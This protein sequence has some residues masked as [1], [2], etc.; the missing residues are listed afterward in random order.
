MTNPFTPADG[1]TPGTSIASAYVFRPSSGS[2]ITCLL[3]IT[4]PSVVLSLSSTRACADT[5]IRSETAPTFNT[6]SNR[7]TCCTANSKPTCRVATNPS[8]LISTSYRP[9]NNAGAE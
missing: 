1:R 9:G 7:A 2:S 8:R 5:S 3:L 6:T 4:C